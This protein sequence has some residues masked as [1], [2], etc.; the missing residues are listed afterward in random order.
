MLPEEF[1]RENEFDNKK[2]LNFYERIVG[3]IVGRIAEALKS[4]YEKH[5]FGHI[6]KNLRRSS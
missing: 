4:L 6:L 5:P 2:I 1:T 3:E